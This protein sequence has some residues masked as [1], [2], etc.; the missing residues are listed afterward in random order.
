MRIMFS[1]PWKVHAWTWYHGT[2]FPTRKPADYDAYRA[3]L[4]ANFPIS[5]SIC[6]TP[7]SRV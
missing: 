4:R 7:A 3:A 1:G 2:L 5:R 6:R